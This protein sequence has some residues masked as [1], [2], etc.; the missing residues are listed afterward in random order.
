MDDDGFREVEK[1]A[2]LSER[3]AKAISR[4]REKYRLWRERSFDKDSMLL[5]HLALS[6]AVEN[7]KRENALRRNA[8]LKLLLDSLDMRRLMI[9]LIAIAGGGLVTALINMVLQLLR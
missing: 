5:D 8:V 6:Q 7:Q 9:V 1:K 4:M 2:Y 3:E